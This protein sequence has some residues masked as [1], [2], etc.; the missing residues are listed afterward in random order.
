MIP[1]CHNLISGY[2]TCIGS[3]WDWAVAVG[4]VALLGA[5]VT[6]MVGTER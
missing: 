2:I 6:L 4:L 1:L 3:A 5:V